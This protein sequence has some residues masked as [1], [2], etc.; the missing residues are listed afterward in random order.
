MWT[1]LSAVFW[2]EKQG[3]VWFACVT[4]GLTRTYHLFI[5]LD[6]IN[7]V[8]CH[9]FPNTIVCPF[10]WLV[11]VVSD[12]QSCWIIS[13]GWDQKNSDRLRGFKPELFVQFTLTRVKWH[14]FFV[15]LD[16]VCHPP[17][18]YGLQHVLRNLLRHVEKR[19]NKPLAYF[20]IHSFWVTLC[21]GCV[22]VIYSGAKKYLVSHQ[23]C[24][25]SHLKSNFHHRYTSTMRD[26]I[27]KKIHK[28]IL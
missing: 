6:Q 5:T 19:Q 3:M 15:T 21:V 8:S 1:P 14:I 16:Y 27:R 2:R 18:L 11:C 23:L 22:C 13:N 9:L 25:F 12:V 20:L 7:S 24:K 17:L 4:V 28:I 26:K 10:A